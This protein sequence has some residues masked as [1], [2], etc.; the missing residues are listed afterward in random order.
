MY[1]RI[2]NIFITFVEMSSSVCPLS[3]ALTDIFVELTK[4]TE[5]KSLCN[6]YFVFHIHR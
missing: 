2:G 6:K 3:N 1:I 4:I 5:M